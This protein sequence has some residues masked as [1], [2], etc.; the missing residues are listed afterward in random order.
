MVAECCHVVAHRVVDLYHV[1]ALEHVRYRGALDCVASVHEQNMIL[2]KCAAYTVD[3]GGLTSRPRYAVL[4]SIDRWHQ[5]AME[6]VGLQ[7]NH[8]REPHLHDHVCQFT[9][10]ELMLRGSGLLGR[11]ESLRFSKRNVWQCPVRDDEV[12]VGFPAGLATRTAGRYLLKVG[13]VKN[14]YLVVFLAQRDCVVPPRDRRTHVDIGLALVVPR[15]KGISS[16]VQQPLRVLHRKCLEIAASRIAV[17]N[18]ARGYGKSYSVHLHATKRLAGTHVD[19]RSIIL[20]RICCQGFPF[21][22]AVSIAEQ[23]RNLVERLCTQIILGSIIS[24]SA[25]SHEGNDCLFSRGWSIGRERPGRC[26]IHQFASLNRPDRSS[27]PAVAGYV[28]ERTRMIATVHRGVGAGN[29]RSEIPSRRRGNR[30]KSPCGEFAK[31][32]LSVER[33][34]SCTIL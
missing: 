7:N 11:D 26:A 2:A 28:D 21:P 31:R 24:V 13:Q 16:A 25:C 18:H 1:L 32:A 34:N 22:R 23:V 12:H 14:R 20:L 10:R 4:V 15:A 29:N 19:G 27:V 3:D 33:I 30:D 17:D 6:I 5:V 8:R 9:P